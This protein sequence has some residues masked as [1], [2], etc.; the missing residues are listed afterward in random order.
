MNPAW[1]SC[2]LALGLFV[3]MLLC[4]EAG[5]RVGR[6]RH[7]R[8]PDSSAAGTGAMEA[9]VF[10]LLGLMLAF[11][12]AGAAE[13]FN[14]R[15]HLIVE[16]ANAIGTAY[17]RLDLLPPE[18]QSALRALFPG[19]VEARLQVYAN[20]ADV[21]ATTHAVLNANRLQQEM[22][23]KAVTA[24]RSAPGNAATL[25]LLP[26]LNAMFDITTDRT[27]AFQAHAPNLIV[28]LLLCLA[29]LSA[30]LAGDMMALRRSRNVF[31][32]LLFA[33]G[34]SLTVYAILDLEYPRF[35]LIRLDWTD[36]VLRQLKAT[37]R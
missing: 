33:L 19:Y 8:T 5:Y 29:L 3:A 35:G 14:H 28:G 32:L 4:L 18:E 15:R 37:M 30:L 21:E 13:R 2:E 24:S 7:E 31:H 20:L 1:V 27:V 25:L 17:L 12:F 11:S 36:E 9:A 16:E 6:R 26:A 23:D 22:W 10:G 34:I